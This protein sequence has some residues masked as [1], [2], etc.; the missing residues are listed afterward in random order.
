MKKYILILMLGLLISISSNSSE[1]KSAYC[2]Q[3][4]GAITWELD[5]K[6]S[7]G[8]F[9]YNDEKFRSDF[10]D[11]SERSIETFP[12]KRSFVFYPVS[13]NIFENFEI[14]VNY[15]NNEEGSATLFLSQNREME[16]SCDLSYKVTVLP[17]ELACNPAYLGTKITVDSCGNTCKCYEGGE[18]ACTE[19]FCE[20]SI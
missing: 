13:S 19:M 3:D 2:W 18:I 14:I 15:E 20:A 8:T 7:E 10:W 11:F 5:L 16:F 9:F 4:D 12:P 1:L 6:S 17:K